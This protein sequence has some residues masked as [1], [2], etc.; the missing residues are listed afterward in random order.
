MTIALRGRM[1]HLTHDIEYSSDLAM[2]WRSLCQRVIRC[3]EIWHEHGCCFVLFERTSASACPPNVH[4]RLLERRFAG[5]S[6][7]AL[8]LDLGLSA[9]T[10]SA[11][12]SAALSELG[13]AGPVS[14]TPILIVMAALAAQGYPTS[15]RL[16]E[17]R[18][19]GRWLVSVRI[20]GDTFRDRLSEG[21]LDVARLSIEGVM[22]REIAQRR[23]SSQRT[24]ANQ[25]ASA[26]RKLGVSGRSELRAIAVQEAPSVVPALLATAS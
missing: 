8:A 20:P 9:G 22:H 16:E 19:D 21:E 13:Y 17:I 14:R 4:L 3:A 23:G 5:E 24:V 12:A 10:V 2:L 6:Q 26:F 15:A 11:Y 18:E 25:L 1:Q 7:K